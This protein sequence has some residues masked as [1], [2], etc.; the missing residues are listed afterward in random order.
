[1]YGLLS[2]FDE[3]PSGGVRDEIWDP[4]D[5][6]SLEGA[7]TDSE[8]DSTSIKSGLDEEESGLEPPSGYSQLWR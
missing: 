2:G 5:L 4:I 6:D 3:L 1:M 7:V 8:T